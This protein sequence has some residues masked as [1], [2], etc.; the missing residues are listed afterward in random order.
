MK[1]HR[2]HVRRKLMENNGKLNTLEASMIKIPESINWYLFFQF[3]LRI[4]LSE[5]K[6]T[7]RRRRSSKQ[8]KGK[9]S[10]GMKIKGEERKDQ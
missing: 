5:E 8:R 3:V 1:G 7:K 9:T 10:K 2:L 6:S 4:T